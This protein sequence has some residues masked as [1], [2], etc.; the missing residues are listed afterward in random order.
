M[1]NECGGGSILTSGFHVATVN[2]SLNIEVKFQT[3]VMPTVYILV[4]KELK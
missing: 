1:E 4:E 3:P 2:E